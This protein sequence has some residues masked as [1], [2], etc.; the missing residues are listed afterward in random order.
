MLQMPQ[1]KICGWKIP[2]DIEVNSSI[3]L[4]ISLALI[5]TLC[6]TQHNTHS[7][8]VYMEHSPRETTLWAIKVMDVPMKQSPSNLHLEKSFILYKTWRLSWVSDNNMAK[9]KADLLHDRQHSSVIAGDQTLGRKQK[10][11][12]DTTILNAW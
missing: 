6:P 7:L 1:S 8:Q 2:K 11:C 9:K 12:K 4:W 5:N 3:F 10:R